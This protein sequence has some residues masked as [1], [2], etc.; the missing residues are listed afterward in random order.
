MKLD[1]V[2]PGQAAIPAADYNAM[3]DMAKAFYEGRLGTSRPP[4]P[5][6]YDGTV[7]VRN[8]S[9]QAMQR[10]FVL[11]IAGPVIEPADN[12]EEFQ[13]RLILKGV[14]P[15]KGVH[16]NRFIILE[17][18]IASGAIGRGRVDG[19]CVCKIVGPPNVDAETTPLYASAHN[20]LGLNLNANGSARVLWLEPGNSRRWALVR[21]NDP[22]NTIFA[23]VTEVANDHLMA[24]INHQG[25]GGN[26]EPITVAKPYKLRHNSYNYPNVEYLTSVDPNT[27]S[28]RALDADEGEETWEVRPWAYNVG[29]R[30]VIARAGDNGINSSDKKEWIDLNIDARH[31]A[32][33]TGNVGSAKR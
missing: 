4:Q 27:V 17:E 13:H 20:I 15:L 23:T 7:L 9:G 21:L 11:G 1:Y 24:K 8:D 12:L 18:P 29:D 6:A 5:A 14:T 28:V 22:P 31:W 3:I 16:E 26:S 25:I 33:V 32:D 19:I 10:F 30:I 2:R